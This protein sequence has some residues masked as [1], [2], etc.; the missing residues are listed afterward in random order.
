[1]GDNEGDS[2]FKAR[3]DRMFAVA[4]AFGDAD[5]FTLRVKDSLDCGWTPRCAKVGAFGLAAG[6]VVVAQAACSGMIAQTQSL[7]HHSDAAIGRALSHVL[8]WRLSVSGLPFS[9]ELV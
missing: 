9:G 2:A 6:M 1:M 7:P 4:P 8:P 3:L 5:L